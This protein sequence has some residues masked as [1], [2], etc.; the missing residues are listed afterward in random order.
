MRAVI[1]ENRVPQAD[2]RTLSGL[3][4]EIGHLRTALE[5]VVGG[6][7]PARRTAPPDGISSTEIRH[8]KSDK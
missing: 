4:A 5:A 1:D 3:A 6:V 7:P 8:R 2:A